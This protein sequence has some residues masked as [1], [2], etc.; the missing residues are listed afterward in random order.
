MRNLVVD[1]SSLIDKVKDD[2]CD[3]VKE[4]VARK[5]TLLRTSLTDAVKM[6]SKH[7]RVA[8]THIFVI[9][10]STETRDRKPYA[11]PVQCLPIQT[12][13]D[14]QARDLANH[15]IAAMVQRG[16]K[17]AGEYCIDNY[18]CK[19]ACILVKG[20]TTNGE[21]NSLRWKGNQRPLTVLDVKR[22]ARSKYKNKGFRTLIKMLSPVG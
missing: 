6:L 19:A 7:Q 17:I 16:M 15:V 2:Q 1:I 3:L 9:M 20:F 4:N 13:R 5:L 21:F 11:L 22:K 12:L 18:F 8:A 10:I 14:Q